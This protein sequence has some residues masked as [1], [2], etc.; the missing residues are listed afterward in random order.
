MLPYSFRLYTDENYLGND[1]NNLE[2]K[3]D[4]MFFENYEKDKKFLENV[5]NSCSAG[6]DPKLYSDVVMQMMF[7]HDEEKNDLTCWSYI[8]SRPI[9]GVFVFMQL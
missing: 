3:K 7:S 4:Q 6:N 8:K 1:E 2:Y 5:I 9:E